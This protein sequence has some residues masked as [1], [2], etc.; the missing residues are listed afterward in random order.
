MEKKQACKFSPRCFM[1][2]NAPVWI[3]FSRGPLS[4]GKQIV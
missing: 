2:K 1:G 3:E 4:L